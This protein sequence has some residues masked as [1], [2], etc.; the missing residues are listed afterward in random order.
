MSQPTQVTPP[1]QPLASFVRAS[2][3]SQTVAFLSAEQVA[4]DLADP[5]QRRFGDY[6]LIER[7]GQGGMGVV[8]RARQLG[9]ERD[10]AIKL[11]AAEVQEE[12]ESVLAKA[13]DKI[14]HD[15]S[16]TTIMRTGDAATAICRVAEEQ[17]CDAIMMG[18]RGRGR[19]GALL[20]SVSQAV[21]HRARSN[22]IVVHA[23]PAR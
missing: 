3:P 19:I 22:V 20:G 15:V 21:M 17:R 9:L 23:P 5:A 4:I 10:V 2:D 14:P 16:V 6:E 12:M 1:G 13:R 18:S 7:V 11:L 8:Y